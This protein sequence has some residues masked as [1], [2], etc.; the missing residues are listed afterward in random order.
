MEK[1]VNQTLPFLVV[2][3]EKDNGQFLTSIYRKSTFTGQYI[4]IFAGIHLDHQNAK[5]ANPN[6]STRGTGY[7]FQNQTS[8][9][10]GVYTIYL[11]AKWQPR[12]DNPGPAP[13]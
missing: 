2:E 7:L 8:T 10:T 5:P 12:S 3:I 11:A 9:R 1:E 4:R 6:S 13:E